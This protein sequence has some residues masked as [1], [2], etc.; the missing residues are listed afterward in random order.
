[1]KKYFSLFIFALISLLVFSTNVSAKTTMTTLPEA[2]QEEINYF[3]NSANF[4]DESTF[5]AYQ[6]YVDVLKTSDLSSYEE[7]DDKINVYVFRGSSCWHCLD[8]IT[9]L[10][11]NY[12]DYAQYINVHTYEVW[13]NSQNSKLMNSVAKLLGQSANGVPFTVVGKQTFSGFAESTGTQI[14]E[15]AKALYNSEDKYD[16]KDHIDLENNIVIGGEDKSSNTAIIVLIITVVVGG[17]ALIYL[18]SK[19]K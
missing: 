14:V 2:V 9:W 5:Q 19:S 11:D 15:K 18:I 3:G 7:S 12:K 16:I 1:M 13:G 6:E 10:A 4:K 8:E 17:A